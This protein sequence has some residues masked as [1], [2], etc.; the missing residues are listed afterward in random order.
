MF[1]PAN[2][3]FIIEGL[4]WLVGRD[5]DQSGVKLLRELSRHSHWFAIR[6]ANFQMHHQGRVGHDIISRPAAFVG[7]CLVPGCGAH[8]AGHVAALAGF[9]LSTIEVG[10]K[11]S[12]RMSEAPAAGGAERTHPPVH[13]TRLVRRNLVQADSYAVLA[14]SS[15]GV[16][17]IYSMAGRSRSSG[18]VAMVVKLSAMAM[19]KQKPSACGSSR[20]S[21]RGRWGHSR[22][23]HSDLVGLAVQS[24]R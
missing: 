22:H 13:H 4:R 16:H 20:R 12:W 21:C 9:R 3:E 8:R 14:R 17:E 23:G 7:N 6:F 24:P 2:R 11:I 15:S 19:R 10:M 18:T 1:I 5:P